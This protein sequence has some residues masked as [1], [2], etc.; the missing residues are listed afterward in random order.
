MVTT[1][2]TIIMMMKTFTNIIKETFPG[3]LAYL[4]LFPLLSGPTK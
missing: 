4:E 2:I 3:G 1:P